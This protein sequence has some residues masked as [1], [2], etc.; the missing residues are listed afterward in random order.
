MGDEE[1]GRKMA[2]RSVR[3]VTAFAA[4]IEREKIIER[5]GRGTEHRVESGTG[6][7]ALAEHEP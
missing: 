3:N 4:E 6:L 5:T 2:G 7:R 1:A